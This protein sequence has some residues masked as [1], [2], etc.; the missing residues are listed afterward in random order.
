MMP[1]LAEK[2]GLP[3]FKTDDNNDM[4]CR[5]RCAIEDEDDLD[6][7]RALN[8]DL[9][10]YPG[11][12][13]Q[14]RDVAKSAA[15]NANPSTSSRATRELLLRN[16]EIAA[17]MK[18]MA[19]LATL[20]RYSPYKRRMFQRHCAKMGC[21][22]PHTLLRDVVTRWDSTKDMIQRGLKLWQG[23]LS[24][25]E[26]ANSP[27]P[28]DKKLKRSDESDFRKLLELLTP[29]AKATK[30]FSDKQA[31]NIGDVIGMFEDLDKHFDQVSRADDIEEVWKQA[32]ARGH[33][34]SAKYYGLTD[35]AN[36]IVLGTL[37]HPNYRKHALSLLKWPRDWQNAAVAQLR[38]V[39]V[40]YYQLDD[41]SPQSESDSQ[42]EAVD[43]LD[44]F[45]KQL[46]QL[47]QS[48]RESSN[49]GEAIDVWL[50]EPI[51]PLSAKG[52]RV[53]ALQWWW[54]EREKGNERSGLTALALDVFSCPATSV[55][56]ERLFSRA[57]RVVTP[58]RHKLKAEKIGQIVT[59]GRWFLEKSVPEELLANML[60]ERAEARR[61]RRAAKSAMLRKRKATTDNDAGLNKRTKPADQM[62]LGGNEENDDSAQNSNL[63]FDIDSDSMQE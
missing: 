3:R 33:F 15:E 39:F 60:E 42:N 10:V 13:D 52:E 57:G 59:L 56:A 41:E 29:I 45:S 4:A 51:T 38:K 44:S 22:E 31:P 18:K 19:W 32:A 43:Q 20:L 46:M 24:F 35:Q 36:V 61:A 16:K 21:E 27:I 25:T 47:A 40:E 1:L 55:D 48:Q 30:K 34:M 14:L 2:S 11:D 54:A 5:V 63:N 8:P 28:A 9:D 17:A 50:K 62:Q 49:P 37:L 26:A 12:E 7:S 58:L 23:I 53:D 6:V